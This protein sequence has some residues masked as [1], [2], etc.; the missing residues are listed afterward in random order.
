MTTP[1]NIAA[2]PQARLSRL[3]QQDWLRDLIQEHHVQVHDL[4]WSIIVRDTSLPATINTMP[5]LIRYTV[6]E[7]PKVITD[8]HNLGIKAIAL[9]TAIPFA[10]KCNQAKLIL[11]DQSLLYQ[12]I[13]TIKAACPD[14]GVIS[15]VALDPFTAH[16]QDCLI[17]DGRVQNDATLAV[18]AQAAVLQAKSGAD[19]IAPSD[20]MD[21]R[22]KVIRSALDEH[23]YINTAIAAYSAKYASSFYSPYRDAVNTNACLGRADKKTYQMN[24]GNGRE[25]EHEVM[26][27]LAEGS[28]IIIIK[29]GLSYLDIV[30][31]I[32]QLTPA[33]V[34]S[35]QVS[36]EYS[37][38]KFA[39]AN[40]A[41]NYEQALMEQLISFKRAGAR[42][43]I[44]YA[45]LDAAQIMRSQQ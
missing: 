24:P 8:A 39:A 5:G 1:L 35:F 14:M 36:G 15:D 45:A 7:L 33:P 44:T 19:I 13:R 34:I 25:A 10:Q 6:E 2:F 38:L 20:M 42:A 4:I 31:R 21:G 9:F 22:V 23:G 37:M 11:D 17:S 43:V 30:K 32:S 12:A 3:R 16:G 26:A 27:D 40:G 41:L 29:P 18:L 28:D